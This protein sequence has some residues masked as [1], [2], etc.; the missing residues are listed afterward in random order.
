MLFAIRFVDKANSLPLRQQMMA[1]H[2]AWLDQEREHVLVG[3]SLRRAPEQAPVGGLWVH[4]GGRGAVEA[5][6]VL[7]RRPAR[8]LGDPALVQGL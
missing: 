1:A 8:E 5:G 6:S 7:H 3:G 4:G 2:I